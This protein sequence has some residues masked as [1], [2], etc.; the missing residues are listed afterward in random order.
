MP[1]REIPRNRRSLT[2][3]VS[4]HADEPQVPFESSLERD[5]VLLSEPDSRVQKIEAQPVRI[6]Y[7]DENMVRFYTPDFLVL[8]HPAAAIGE[9]L[10]PRLVEVKYT[11]DLRANWADYVP[12]FRAAHRYAKARGWA[13]LIRTERH[14]R[15]DEL[16]NRTF[17][18]S[19]RYSEVPF[20]DQRLVLDALYEKGAANPQTLIEAM[21]EDFSRRAYLLHVVWYL[22]ANG[23]IG[24][25][26]GKPLTMS[27]TLTNL[28]P[29]WELLGD[30]E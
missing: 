23:F 11:A 8:F 9:T 6:P 25:D 20:H 26:L 15:N 5:F 22:V 18:K 3:L 12:K 2:G 1:V 21:G 27:S 24:A 10:R 17:L 7:K 4:V 14:I 30:E 28:E 19:Y 29:A 13:F 16:R